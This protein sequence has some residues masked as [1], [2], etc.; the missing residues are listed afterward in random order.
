M[1]TRGHYIGQII[2]E[3]TAVSNQVKARAGLQ[4]TDLNRYLEDF[5]KEVLNITYGYALKNLNQERSNYPGLDLGDEK[6]GV[7]FQVTSTKSLDKIHKTLE[8]AAKDVGTYPTVYVLILVDKQGS[9]A[10]KDEFTKPFG[11]EEEK[12]ILDIQD[13]LAK[14]LALPIE[15]LQSLHELVSAEVARVKIELE[16]PDRNG[17]YQTNIDSY[18]EEIPRE[19]FEGVHS[20]F[21]FHREFF[22]TD[23]L[24]EADV[25]EGFRNLVSTLQKLPRITRQFY[26]FLLERSRWDSDRRVINHDYL[27]RI[28]R[29]PDMDGELRLL[30]EQNLVIFYEAQAFDE[31]PAWHMHMYGGKLKSMALEV[32]DFVEKKGLKFDKFIVSLDFS[33]FK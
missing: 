17:K 30:T 18:I 7:A 13:V 24:T 33:D 12:H 6:E 5:F 8:K 23:E 14:A 29:V 26:A 19:R 32:I 11:F 22:D 25:E 2:D 27:K 15:R 1:I 31:S 28:C 20:Y 4:L 3:L 21:L 9:Y 16:I 10:L